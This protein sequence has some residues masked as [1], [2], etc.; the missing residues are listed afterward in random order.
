LAKIFNSNAAKYHFFEF[1]DKKYF[2]IHSKSFQTEPIEPHSVK[3]FAIHEF[4]DGP[5][6]LSSS[7]HITQGGL[8]ITQ[9]LFNPDSNSLFISLEK[10]GT[11]KGNLYIYLPA[12]LQ[13]PQID[14]EGSCKEINLKEYVARNKGE[15]APTQEPKPEKPA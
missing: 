13:T 5:T 8:E 9:F 2:G 10:Q 1:W 14:L 11:N 15:I 12:P 6:L 7:F 4:K 3:L